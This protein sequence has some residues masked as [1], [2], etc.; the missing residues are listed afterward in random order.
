MIFLLYIIGLIC[1]LI[2]LKD[3][4]NPLWVDIL[5]SIFWPIPVI[6]IIIFLIGVIFYNI[7]YE[8]KHRH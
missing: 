4:T 1:F 5:L 7:F 6:I 8:I 2:L 3:S